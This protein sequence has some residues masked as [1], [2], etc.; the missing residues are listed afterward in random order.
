M[1]N[2]HS[3]S[4]AIGSRPRWKTAL[5]VILF[6]L[7]YTLTKD[8]AS[9]SRE[10]GQITK[11]PIWVGKT[12]F[13]RQTVLFRRIVAIVLLAAAI[14]AALYPYSDNSPEYRDVA[15]TAGVLI[16]TIA[17]FVSQLVPNSVFFPTWAAL[18]IP[19]IVF[20][21][22]VVLP[23]VVKPPLWANITFAICAVFAAGFSA[24]NRDSPN[25]WVWT[26]LPTKD[27]E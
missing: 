9:I 23:G 17:V 26:K 11:W 16:A 12:S 13:G 25:V 20:E 3:G 5:A 18:S 15:L 21:F 7:A 19:L 1:K 4:G 6:G 14:M 8:R 22:V 10:E 24:I 2:T 27:L